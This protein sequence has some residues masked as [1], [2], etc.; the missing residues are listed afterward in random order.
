MLV[1]RLSFCGRS[2]PANGLAVPLQCTLEVCAG[3]KRPVLF[4]ARFV[5]R[6]HSCKLDAIDVAVKPDADAPKGS[7]SNPRE[8][9]LFFA[10]QLGVLA[11]GNSA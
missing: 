10:C 4:H 9:D 5:V 6:N 1:K 7:S 8:D 3:S 2:Q 11:V